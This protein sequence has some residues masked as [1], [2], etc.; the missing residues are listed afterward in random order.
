MKLDRD[1]LDDM[2]N[3]KNCIDYKGIMPLVEGFGSP[4]FPSHSSPSEIDFRWEREWRTS[5]DF[6]FLCNEVAFGICP[7]SE[8][9]YFESL[10]SG[11]IK[12]VDVSNTAQLALAKTKLTTD[13]RFANLKL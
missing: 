10:T 9:P 7:Q 4:W 1:G 3:A 11:E 2:A 6:D 12:F 5:M 8:I 13:P